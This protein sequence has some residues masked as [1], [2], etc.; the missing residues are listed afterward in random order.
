MPISQRVSGFLDSH[1]DHADVVIIGAGIVGI[2]TAYYLA[3]KNIRVAILEK[4]FVGGEQSSRNW[5]WLRQQNRGAVELPMAAFSL[6]AWAD[7]EAEIDESIGFFQGGTLFVTENPDDMRKWEAWHAVAREH[8]LDSRIVSAAQARAM[9][10]GSDRP[11]IGGLYTASDAR[12]EPMLAAPA[13]ARAA[14]R[15]GVAIHQQCA[16]RG[17]LIEGGRVAG[18]VTEKG[19]VRT[20]IVLCAGGIWS[21]LLARRHGIRLPQVGIRTSALRTSPVEGVIDGQVMTPTFSARK[22]VDGGYTIGLRSRGTIDLTVDA[23]RY[24][25][26]FFPGYLPMRK[27]L[28]VGF[29]QPFWDSIKLGRR[30]EL[31]SVSPF[32]QVRVLNPRPNPAILKMAIEGARAAIPALKQAHIAESWGG[33]LDFTPDQLPVISAV[34]ALPGFYLATGC[35]GHGFG[36]ASGIGAAAASLVMGDLPPFDLTAFRF[37]RMN[38][39]SKLAPHAL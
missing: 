9:A 34:D 38:D 24:A 33:V 22:R 5:G 21:T 19:L 26:Q 7:I 11:W 1:P 10:K 14:A 15:R 29:G 4:G 28:S 13:I 12:A 37:N 17:L 32:E 8:G 3:K 23:F 18:V 25:R 30:W 20:S 31:D 6:Q 2:W 16:A 27:T 35:S 36:V 39:G